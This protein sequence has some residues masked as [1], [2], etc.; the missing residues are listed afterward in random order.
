[1]CIPV[2]CTVP[3][4]IFKLI[5]TVT[6][7]YV[8]EFI[9]LFTGFYLFI[10]CLEP[11]VHKVVPVAEPSRS[12]IN[13][14]NGVV[15]P[16]QSPGSTQLCTQYCAAVYKFDPHLFCFAYPDLRQFVAAKRYLLPLGFSGSK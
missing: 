2:Y 1:M 12:R 13:S 14:V 9:Y 15:I 11:V 8:V 10:Y 3:I 6:L 16:N 4:H 7:S 5:G